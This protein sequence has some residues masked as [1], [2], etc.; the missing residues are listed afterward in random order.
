MFVF[1]LSEPVFFRGDVV[2]ALGEE[3]SLSSSGAA[4]D[5][6]SP[7]QFEIHFE[8]AIEAAKIDHLP[9]L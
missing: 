5:L 3:E 4:E 8:A 7:R 1:Y 9:V 2:R 6:H